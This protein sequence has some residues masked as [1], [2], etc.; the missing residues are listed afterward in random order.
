MQ[1]M[2][3]S[4][5]FRTT[6]HHPSAASPNKDGI[7]D[8]ASGSSPAFDVTATNLPGQGTT[9]ERASAS[10]CVSGYE[11]ESVLGRGGMGVVCKAQHLALKRSH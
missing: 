3:S 1:P 8:G 4:D 7:A 2:N 6:D 11:I 10:V 5:P 9:P